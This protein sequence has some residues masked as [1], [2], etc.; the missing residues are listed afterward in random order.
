MNLFFL[1]E[2]RIREEKPKYCNIEAFNW[3]YELH[4]VVELQNIE[5]KY[6]NSDN[7]V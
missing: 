1:I 4:Q 6:H 3:S 5:M 7:L 2:T